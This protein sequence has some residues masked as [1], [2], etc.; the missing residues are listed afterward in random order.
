MKLHQTFRLEESLIKQLKEQA[1]LENRTVA[2]LVE[3]ILLTFLNNINN[4]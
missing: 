2:N 4:G 3:T 1:A